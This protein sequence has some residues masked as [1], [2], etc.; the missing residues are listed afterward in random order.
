MTRHLIDLIIVNYNSTDCLLGC[1][2][3]VFGAIDRVQPSI[4]IQDNASTDNVD[5]V[6]DRYPEVKLTKNNNNL[7]FARG[8]NAAL[9]QS[10][11][12]YALLLN[13]DT[14]ISGGLFDFVFNYMEE[15]PSVGVLGPKILDPDGSVQGSARSFPT[16][17]TGLFGR[18]SLLTKLFPNNPFS[19]SNILSTGHSESSPLEVDWVSGACMIVR[20]K[21]IEQ[22]GYLDER[23]FMYWE[24]ADWCRRMKE[25][26]WKVIYF[27]RA[28]VVHYVGGSSDS[29]AI[30]SL[31]E[32]HKS[33]YRLYKKYNGPLFNFVKPLAIVA[34]AARLSL[35]ICRQGIRL[36][37]SKRG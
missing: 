27:P 23:F 8:V 16:L 17:L 34:L 5:R 6:I 1:L 18:T 32:F 7:G 36:C 12:P 29:R 14:C 37:A 31:I 21:A 28:S 11:S 4:Y 2:D 22:V 15:N 13:P 20:R 3:S 30:P 33:C 35:C 9:R 19:R 26:G 25:R 10:V 24:D